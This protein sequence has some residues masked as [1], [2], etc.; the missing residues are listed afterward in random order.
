MGER[1]VASVSFGKDSLAM[2]QLLIRKHYPLDEV[3][4][5][6]T[7]MEFQAI[8][9]IRDR[10]VPILKEQ[11][12]VY[13]ELRPKRPFLYDMFDKP[14][15][16]GKKG[17]GWCG[18][19]CRWGTTFKTEAIDTYAKQCKRYIGIAA[20]ET[21][22]LNRPIAQ[23]SF[24]LYPLVSEGMTE[25][26]CL[27]ECYS[28]GF[29]WEEDGGAGIVRLYD[30]LDHVSCWCCRNKNLKELKN[31]Y[32]Y[33]PMYWERLKALQSRL[34]TPMKG[35]GKSLFELEERFQSELAQL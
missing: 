29:Y 28:N 2:L 31:I 22:R 20:D 16:N 6:D 11:G 17:Y 9:A 1:Y 18:G 5:Y 8:Y 26:D 34:V 25:Q 10:I 14:K 32:Q 21:K 30:I 35:P 19:P 23:N 27:N 13:T 12:I 24:K 3:V 33:L 15:K 7:G 4:F